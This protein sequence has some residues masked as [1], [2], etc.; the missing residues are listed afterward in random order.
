MD[1]HMYRVNY[2]Y[3][4]S[5]YIWTLIL[6]SG[7]S[8]TFDDTSVTSLKLWARITDLYCQGCIMK[9]YLLPVQ[10][11]IF[12][13]QVFLKEYVDFHMYVMF[14]FS[15]KCFTQLNFS[16]NDTLIHNFLMPSSLKLLF[17][18]LSITGMQM[19]QCRHLISKQHFTW[20]VLLELVSKRREKYLRRFC[21]CSLWL[22]SCY[23]N[24]MYACYYNL[25][26]MM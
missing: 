10:I 3:S 16:C 1:I 6:C 13:I 9:H 23:Y 20:G 19:R 12:W 4:T 26:D 5:W 15:W 25:I 18:Y 11:N 2:Q 8:K 14:Y 17:S 7:A 22:L 24:F 21:F